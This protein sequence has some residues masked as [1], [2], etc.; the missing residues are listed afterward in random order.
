MGDSIDDL[1]AGEAHRWVVSYEND[2]GP[3]QVALVITVGEGT[4]ANLG[5]HRVGFTLDLPKPGEVVWRR[6]SDGR[7]GRGI[8][9]EVSLPGGRTATAQGG[10]TNCRVDDSVV[11]VAL[12][13]ERE[14]TVARIQAMT[15]DFEGIVAAS[16]DANADDEHDPEGATIAF[17]RAQIAGLIA[18]ARAHLDELDRAEERLAA[19]RY[20][21][22]EA[23]GGEIAPDRLAARP[24]ALTC[25]RCASSF[26]TH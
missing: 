3:G 10:C 1:H 16:V 5:E 25:F 7:S 9:H 13:A 17:E 20:S 23:C 24:G 6:F 21:V 18:E 2:D 11:R 14:A 26:R 19:G 15:A 8:C 12:L 4:D 22:C